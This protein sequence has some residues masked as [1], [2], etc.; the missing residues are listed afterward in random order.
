M[1][2]GKEEVLSERPLCRGVQVAAG[3]R[4]RLRASLGTHVPG[5]ARETEAA[6]AGAGGNFGLRFELVHTRAGDAVPVQAKAGGSASSSDQ[7]QVSRWHFG[8]LADH[9]RNTAYETAI[10]NVVRRRLQQQAAQGSHAPEKS[11]DSKSGDTHG[12]SDRSSGL[13]GVSCLDIGAGSGLLAMIAARAPC[14]CAVGQT[15]D[16]RLETQP[17]EA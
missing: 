17:P 7:S 4:L 14:L 11:N 12:C 8:M 3:Q 6:G 10:A 16:S 2:S 13:H 5:S 9:A 1:P 15:R